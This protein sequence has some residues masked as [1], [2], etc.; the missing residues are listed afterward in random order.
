MLTA[1]RSLAGTWVAK[2]LFLLLVLSFAAWG[3]DD[4]LRNIGR[5]NAIAR[6]DG[7]AIEVEEADAAARRE[8]ARVARNLGAS[9]QPDATIRRAV[10]NEALEALIQDRLLRAEADRLGLAV[11]DPAV[12]A[13]I[14]ATPGFRGGDGGFSRPVFDAFLRGNGITEAYFV[15]V[16]RGDMLRRQLADAVR[17]G[18]RAPMAMVAPLTAWA[19]ETRAAVLVTL[20][21]ADQPTPEPPDDATLRRFQANE[22]GR[23]ST[24]ELREAEIAVLSA[25]R[26]MREVQV[27]DAELEAAYEARRGQFEVPERRNISQVLVADEAAAQAIAT[28]WGAGAATAEITERATAANGQL[29]DLGM[30]DRAAL[31]FPELADAAFSLAEGNVSLPVRSPF[32]WHVLRVAAIAP[33]ESRSLDA[34]RAELTAAVASEKAADLAFERVNKVED[35]L[36]G[37]ATLAEVAER[38]GLGH[39]L[40]AVDAQGRDAAGA[41]VPLPVQD[42]AREP[43]LQAIFKAEAGVAPRL[44][45]TEAGF[46][47]VSLRQ[48]TPPALRPFESVEAEVRAA[49]TEAQQRRVAEEKAAALLGATRAGKTLAEAAE[50]AGLGWRELGAIGRDPRVAIIPREL[51]GPLFGLKQDETTMVGTAEGFTVAQLREIAVASAET[52][53]ARA[54]ALRPQLSEVLAGD[55]EAQYLAALRAR[56]DVR[57]NP[58][59]FDRIAQP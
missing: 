56:A 29:L 14:R 21:A 2:G 52:V 53:A 1:L 5:D 44:A 19:L 42:I 49:W 46:V 15:G 50:A 26:L 13:E 3:I 17:A 57:I 8:L 22:A 37:G 41:A 35:A 30:V 48:V 43:L 9:F 34:V 45:E 33:G 47:A 24:P 31:P 55:F 28:A 58:R 10:A 25:D 12:A 51:V 27:T 16:V 38:F 59:L 23:F 39:A 11:P 20:A 32:G 54:E 4:V 7:V 6:V 36:A 40:V 18:A